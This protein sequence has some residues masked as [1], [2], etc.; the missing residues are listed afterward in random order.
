MCLGLPGEVV[1]WLE[2][3]PLFA[4][5]EIRFGGVRKVCHMAC[6]PEAEVGVGH[7]ERREALEVRAEQDP[8]DQSPGSDTFDLVIASD[9]LHPTADIA[10][11]LA[12]Y[13]MYFGNANLIN[14]ELEKYHQVTRE[15]IREVAR[16]YLVPENRVTLYYL[17]K[18]EE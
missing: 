5:A 9:A 8:A 3:D 10:A 2:R 13:H 16:K 1:E 12:N 17:P 14:T 11:S 18:N 15:K 6:V 7:G 4:R